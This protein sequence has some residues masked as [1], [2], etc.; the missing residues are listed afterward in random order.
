MDKTDLKQIINEYL[1]GLL[2]GPDI[3]DN[4][5]LLGPGGILDSVT[6]A[7]LIHRL[8]ERFGINLTDDDLALESL[9]SINSLAELLLRYTDREE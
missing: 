7:A 6:A 5:P 8:E 2:G 1:R 9:G 4:H 3:G